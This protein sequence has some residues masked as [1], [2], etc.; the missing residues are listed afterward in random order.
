MLKAEVYTA[1]ED[2]SMKWYS[3]SKGA[4]ETARDESGKCPDCRAHEH[5]KV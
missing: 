2:Y 5:K 4:S 3:Y 1:M